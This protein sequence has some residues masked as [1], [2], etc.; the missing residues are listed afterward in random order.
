MFHPNPSSSSGNHL[1]SA[2]GP[3]AYG[4]GN[5]SQSI[6]WDFALFPSTDAGN[7]V[8][9]HSSLPPLSSSSSSVAL[10]GSLTSTPD[11]SLDYSPN[12]N[13]FS[14]PSSGAQH[15]LGNDSQLLSGGPIPFTTSEAEL[16]SMAI[17]TGMGGLHDGHFSSP[18]VKGNIFLSTASTSTNP[19]QTT[20]PQAPPLAHTTVDLHRQ[21]SPLPP[22]I[23]AQK[24]VPLLLRL[25]R[26]RSAKP[27]PWRRAAIARSAW[28]K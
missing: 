13:H 28:T 4:S 12:W 8:A 9:D 21:S 20:H 18:M 27:T 25:P 6:N 7:L 19:T 24:S 16:H 26:S 17:S 22:N 1:N 14:V 10:N 23:Q 2:D 15:Y 3:D 11:L 5:G